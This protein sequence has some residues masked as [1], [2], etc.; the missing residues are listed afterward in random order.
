MQTVEQELKEMAEWAME[1]EHM[2]MGDVMT[3]VEEELMGTYYEVVNDYCDLCQE[4]F[5][6][7]RDRLL[8]SVREHIT[9]LHL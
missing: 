5:Y 6:E 8:S 2:F 1:Q 4:D 7:V 3:H 9:C